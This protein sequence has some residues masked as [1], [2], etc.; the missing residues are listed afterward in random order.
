M[1]QLIFSTTV[2]LCCI[3]TL[4]AQK[5]MSTDVLVI[6]GSAGG[7]AAGIQCARSGVKTLIVEQT[8]WLGGM[9]TAA[10]VS[11][12]DGND[13]LWSGLW[14]EFREQLYLHYGTRNLFTGWVSETCFEP[15]V[16]DS[17]LKKMAAKEKSLT[18]AYGWYFD[19]VVM[20][21]D[22]VVGAAFM[23][24]TGEELIVKASLTIDATDLGD[25]YASS[26]AG[27]DLGME[28]PVYSKEAIAPGTND[29]I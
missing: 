1:K 8:P 13:E 29:I 6:G 10:G 26:G 25:A 23:N 24:A 3:I 7:T 21:G 14:M 17:I 18:V 2:L 12:T 9:L 27:Y 22:Q 20:R 5:R 19:H 15:R 4:Q 28:D 11:C 16:G